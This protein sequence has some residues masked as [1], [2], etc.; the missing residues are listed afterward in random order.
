M[1]R[2]LGRALGEFRKG[3]HDLKRTLEADLRDVEDAVTKED[4]STTY[5]P[6]DG[7]R[8]SGKTDTQEP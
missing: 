2:A 4:P 3:A 8:P 7:P 6:P 1:G 5:P